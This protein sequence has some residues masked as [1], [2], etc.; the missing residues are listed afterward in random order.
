[1]LLRGV[2]ATLLLTGAANADP[3]SGPYIGALAGYNR[4]I[5]SADLNRVSN[6]FGLGPFV[7]PPAHFDIQSDI[8]T[9]TFL[10]GWGQASATYYWGVEADITFAP[11]ETVGRAH[12]PLAELIPGILFAM[13]VN[14]T[15]SERTTTAT[16][17][18]RLGVLPA[19]STLIYITG[20]LAVARLSTIF[21]MYYPSTLINGFPV[22]EGRDII[23]KADTVTGFVV[24]AGIEQ[25]LAGNFSAR[26]EYAF[27]HFN[28]VGFQDF[29]SSTRT[30]YTSDTDSHNFRAGIVYRFTVATAQAAAK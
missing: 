18:A 7:L 16:L 4:T 8:P 10:L 28:S 5:G 15:I 1:M 11:R 3:F 6:V 29:T 13:P 12:T 2:L 20:G 24:G 14:F 9:G 27:I 23:K 17:R 26:A 25:N 30:T 19:P 22:P 21:D